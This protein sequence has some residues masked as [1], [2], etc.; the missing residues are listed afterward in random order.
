[1]KPRRVA[2]AAAVT[3]LAVALA[4]CGTTPK[5]SYYTLA[6]GPVQ[7]D[8]AQSAAQYTVAVGPVTLPDAVD[9]PQLVV[10][11]ATNQVA[12]L[13]QHRWAEPLKS[14]IPR[15]IAGNLTQLLG[16]ARVW[17][18]PQNTGSDADYRVRVD[19]VSFESAPGDS[20]TLG[21]LW[22]VERKAAG[23]VRA[24]RSVIQLPAMGPDY[25]AVV[26]AHGR[27]LASLSEELGE[28]IRAMHAGNH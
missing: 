12:L 28:V 24:G 14:E 26:A 3:L 20:V 17:A 2:G 11:V 4:G 27:A 7:P 19:I 9:R 21:A 18:Y 22:A 13:D 16:M 10:R 5:T 25:A 1:M 15:V 23:E 6:P 8:A